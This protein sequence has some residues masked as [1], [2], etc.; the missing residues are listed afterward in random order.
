M[1]K[2]RK[3][4]YEIIDIAI[5]NIPD[6]FIESKKYIRESI[7]KY[8]EIANEIVG[9]ENEKFYKAGFCDGMSLKS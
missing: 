9:Y 2:K 6:L 4:T 5:D 7:E 8:L 3:E 1:L